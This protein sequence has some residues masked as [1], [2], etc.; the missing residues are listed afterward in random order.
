MPKHR[1]FERRNFS[2]CRLFFLLNVRQAGGRVWYGHA[3]L[4]CTKFFKDLLFLECIY[5][6]FEDM[7]F[8]ESMNHTLLS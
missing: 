6:F 8:F 7:K 3:F 2:A 5:D 4:V 1:M